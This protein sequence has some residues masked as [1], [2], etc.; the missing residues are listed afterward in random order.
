MK[1]ALVAFDVNETLLDLSVLEPAFREELGPGASV[2]EWFA[3]MA[4]RS[5]VANHLGR[6]RPFG[7]LGAEV[8][9]WLAHREGID[10]EPDA[11][12]ALVAGMRRLPPHPEVEDGLDRLRAAGFRLVVLTNG[13]PDAL[14]AQMSFSGLGGYFDRHLSVEAIGRFKP[15]PEVYLHAAA[16][17]GVDI[18][19]MML[20][21]AHD[22]DVAGARSV[23]AMGCFVNR[24]PWGIADPLPTLTV[25]DLGGLADA[26]AGS[27]GI[28]GAGDG[29]A[30]T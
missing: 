16:V 10:L 7:E 6:Y 9:V 18:D 19:Q 3:R 21:A 17:C 11:A 23:G 4:H 15:A 27:A 29:F 26:L 14:D 25:P 24:Q 1:P 5:L 30:S 20:V 28:D 12:R 13:S 22:W 2:T 8:L